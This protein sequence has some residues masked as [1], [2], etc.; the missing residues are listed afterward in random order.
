MRDV[1]NGDIYLTKELTENLYKVA[2]SLAITLNLRL[3]YDLLKLDF[4]PRQCKIMI[5]ALTWESRG[6]TLGLGE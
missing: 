2:N 1:L 6:P 5:K 3:G 4:H